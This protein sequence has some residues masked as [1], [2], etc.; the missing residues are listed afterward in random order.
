MPLGVNMA[1]A[2]TAFERAG[3]VRSAH[4]PAGRNAA[5]AGSA[6]MVYPRQEGGSPR[7]LRSG[8]VARA[9]HSRGPPAQ[10]ATSA[11]GSTGGASAARSRTNARGWTWKRPSRRRSTFSTVPHIA[12]VPRYLYRK[13]LS[14]VLGL[15]AGGHP[16]RCRGAFD[17]ET[18]LWF[19]A[20]IVKQRWKDSR[21]RTVSHTGPGQ[22][23]T[24]EPWIRP[25][26]KLHRARQLGGGSAVSLVR[27]RDQKTPSSRSSTS[28]GSAAGAGCS[29]RCGRLSTK[30]SSAR[31]ATRIEE[32][33]PTASIFYTSEYPDRIRPLVPSRAIPDPRA[34]PSG[35]ASICI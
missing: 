3:A 26:E 18:W 14:H 34:K 20:G 29:S 27:R 24:V 15:A 23:T 13:A 21:P 4:R 10:G 8:A 17:H 5:R 22:V 2:R 12:G 7:L 9:H 6:R 28:D 19:F 31:S 11:A 35:R 1:F 25:A 33:I 16:R 32:Q 30:P